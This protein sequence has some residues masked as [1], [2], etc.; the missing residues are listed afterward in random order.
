MVDEKISAH[1]ARCA[2]NELKQSGEQPHDYLELLAS[3]LGLIERAERT[4]D[5]HSIRS[6]AEKLDIA[7]ATAH[8][9][10]FVFSRAATRAFEVI[11]KRAL[12]AGRSC[13]LDERFS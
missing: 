8:Q 9:A 2:L 3:C 4:E 10:R 6:A 1:Q 7:V 12:W 11:E 13:V 5:P